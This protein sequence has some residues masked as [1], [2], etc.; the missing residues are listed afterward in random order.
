ME[1]TWGTAEREAKDR[2]SWRKMSSCIIINGQMKE[3]EEDYV[4]MLTKNLKTME[5]ELYYTD[6]E[7]I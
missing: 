5:K 1:L 3:E 4:K 6:N 7:L 2:K